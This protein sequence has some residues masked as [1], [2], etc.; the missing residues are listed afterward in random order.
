MNENRKY[1][2]SYFLPEG[3]C[4]RLQDHSAK[5]FNSGLNLL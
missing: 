1:M 5:A 3:S 2:R 4:I